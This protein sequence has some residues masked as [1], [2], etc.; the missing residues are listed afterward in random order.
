MREC[1]GNVVQR[2]AAVYLRNF[3]NVFRVVEVDEWKFDGLAE[4]EPNECGEAGANASHQR[5]IRN[6]TAHF[7]S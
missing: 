4:D 5:A 7:A 6:F 2:K 1:P 3:V